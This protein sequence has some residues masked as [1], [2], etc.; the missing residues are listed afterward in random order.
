MIG[1]PVHVRVY[2][3]CAN[4][5]VSLNNNS[6]AIVHPSTAN[7]YNASVVVPY[8]PGALSAVCVVGNG[9]P[10][11]S[12]SVT[13]LISSG[14]PHSLRLVSDRST[15]GSSS[16]DLAYV[17]VSLLDKQGVLCDHQRHAVLVNFTVVSSGGGSGGGGGTLYRVGNGDP[18]DTDSFT[19]SQR[20]TWRGNAIAVL[21]PSPSGHGEKEDS[22][23]TLEA[24]APGLLDASVSVRVRGKA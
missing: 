14:E 7:R 23:I 4:V 9:G 16:D 6:I 21:R 15:I 24:S 12:S 8:Q 1:K 20:R 13:Q 10:D 5:E 2:S 11:H 22:T 18:V 19:S 17:T 3:K